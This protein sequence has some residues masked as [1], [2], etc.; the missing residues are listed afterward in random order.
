MG[1]FFLPIVLIGMAAASL[2]IGS[3]YSDTRHDSGKAEA[4]QTANSI[5]SPPANVKSNLLTQGTPAPSKGRLSDL[6]M[7]KMIVSTAAFGGGGSR[8]LFAGN[9]GPPPAPPSAQWNWAQVAGQRY[10]FTGRVFNSPG[11]IAFSGA[12]NG[13]AYTDAQGNFSEIFSVPTPGL[14]TASC[15]DANGNMVVVGT[16]TLT[17]IPP[18][19]ASFTAAWGTWPNINYSGTASDDLNT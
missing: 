5:A 1:R 2:A 16:A 7:T 17:N 14:V 13:V 12:A 4:A 6:D 9:G 8:N 10:L 3:V 19:L 11:G 15:G 18:T